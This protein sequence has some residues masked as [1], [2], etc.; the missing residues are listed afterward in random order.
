MTLSETGRLAGMIDHF[1][2]KLNVYD[3]IN[4]QI[5]DAARNVQSGRF[6]WNFRSS[7]G[8]GDYFYPFG[9]GVVSGE[10]AGAVIHQNGMMFIEG[11]ITYFY[12]DTFTD[13]ASVREKIIPGSSS[14]DASFSWWVTLTDGFGQ[15]FSISDSWSSVFKS[16]AKFD[17]STS[18]Y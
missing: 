11:E 16:E 14:V 5:V 8:F 17:E 3:R 18:I 4:V 1:F 7:Y 13:P 9:D 2:Y 15:Y 12:T 10:F 6:H